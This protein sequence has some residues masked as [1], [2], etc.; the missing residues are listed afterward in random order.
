[1]FLAFTSQG[2][3]ENLAPGID[4][5]D[6]LEGVLLFLAAVKQF[7]EP[8]IFGPDNGSF[9][10]IVKEEQDGFIIIIFFKPLL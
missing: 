3:Q 2:Q 4:Q 9:G 7:L 8:F 6:V 10:A 1:M 5:D